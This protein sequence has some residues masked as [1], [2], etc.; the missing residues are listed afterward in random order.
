MA[1]RAVLSFFCRPSSAQAWVVLRSWLSLE[2]WADN[3][4]EKGDSAEHGNDVGSPEECC[5][6][7]AFT[8]A[9]EFLVA[10]EALAHLFDLVFGEALDCH[11]NPAW[12][13]ASFC[14]IV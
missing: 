11:G 9:V 5:G 13:R 2:G 4:G 14:Q 3:G 7:H 10:L 1:W 8:E 12:F 6:R